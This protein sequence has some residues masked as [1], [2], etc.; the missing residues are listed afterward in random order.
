VRPPS[1]TSRAAFKKVPNKTR[2]LLL[3][4]KAKLKAVLLHHARS[5]NVAA[6]DVVK[7]SSPRL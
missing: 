5:G 7:L 1:T 2:S 3:R 4:K 6:A